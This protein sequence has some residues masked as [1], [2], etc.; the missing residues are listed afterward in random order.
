[1]NMRIMVIDDS[2]DVQED[3]KKILIK[4]KKDHDAAFSELDKNLFGDAS[5]E[6]EEDKILSNFT[7]DTASQGKEGFEKIA[8]AFNAGKPYAL[9]FVDIRMP[10]G[11][12]GVQTIKEI[13]RV[14]PNIQIVICTAYSDYS[15]EQTIH[16]LGQTDNLLI[17][18]KPIDSIAVRQLASALTKKWQL[19]KDAREYALS[20]EQRV[21]ERTRSL[22]DTIAR[23]RATIESS[24]DGMVVLDAKDNIIDFNN[25]FI[26]MWN[27]VD[28]IVTTKKKKLFFD[29]I[30]DQIKPSEQADIFVKA[31]SENQDKIYFGRLFLTNKKVYEYYSQPYNET[32]EPNARVWSFRDI[33][34]SASIE[35]ELHYKATHDALTG[36]PN[37][38]LIMDEL[39]KSLKN[40]EK[41]H[42]SFGVLFLDLDR[43]KLVNDSLSHAA[44]DEVL[45]SVSQRLQHIIRKRDVLG[46][47]G[48][49]E[50]II[51]VNDMQHENDLSL[52]SEKILE[53]FTESF[54]IQGHE[55]NTSASIGISVYPK[56]GK[57]ADLL[58]SA[59]DVA[60]YLSK[61]LG[62]NQY[63]FYTNTLGTRSHHQ[64]EVES[65]LRQAIINNEFELYYQP[66]IDLRTNTLVS[67][68]ALIRWNQP[69][70]GLILPMNFI[71][72]AEETG[73]IV[74]IGEWVLRTV[75]MQIKQWEN[76]GIPLL[77]VAVNI[78]T[79]Q[80]RQVGFDK[81]VESILKEYDVAPEFLELELTEN[82]LINNLD[83]SNVIVNL[84][85]LGVQISLDDFG[86]GYSSLNYLRELPIDRIKIDQSYVRNIEQGRGD[87]VII[88]A[89]IAM[90]QS[91]KLEVLA[92]G[93]ENQNQ[94]DFL[95]NNSCGTIQGYYYSKPLTVKE[96][97][98]FI[99]E[100]GWELGPKATIE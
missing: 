95:L 77:R 21:E 75:C 59:A 37:R 40:S 87:S 18:K 35:E 33:T 31:V 67:M 65:E 78:A 30:I 72:L 100:R 19:M 15:W 79:K 80:L 13:W 92:E 86:A 48:G 60:M 54:N 74:P 2:N 91:M 61:E 4:S 58:L 5:A 51:I 3:F 83:M 68:E 81:I 6:N 96:I 66:Q 53:S 90:A 10:P 1:M 64:Q 41:N 17:L 47:L 16:E 38:V 8:A 88:Q 29:F 94:L 84:K 9:A 7:I 70:K 20:L 22:D 25:K 46:R 52:F 43:F 44:G 24:A 57:N 34:I 36:L 39:N 11:M 63:N 14:D 45:R 89:I 82:I 28:S 98:T 97:E 62:S 55:F 71:P 73:L 49:D 50:F 26:S 27:I 23:M 99:K 85:K 42:T 56:D 32:N 12:D 76:E 69:T 93:V